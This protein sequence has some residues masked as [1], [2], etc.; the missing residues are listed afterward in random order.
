MCHADAAFSSRES[1]G[2]SDESGKYSKS[3]I[4][5]RFHSISDSWHLFSIL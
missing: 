4:G 2:Q 1:D 5:N 3:V